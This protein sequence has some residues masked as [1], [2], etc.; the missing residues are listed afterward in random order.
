MAMVEQV[1]RWTAQNLQSRARV[2]GNLRP[3][4]RTR[5]VAQAHTSQAKAQTKKSAVQLC[6]IP[7]ARIP[8]TICVPLTRPRQ[9]HINAIQT[10]PDMGNSLTLTVSHLPGADLQ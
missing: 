4:A 5:G 1:A 10:E 8:T 7:T 6:C 3:S 9:S 2:T